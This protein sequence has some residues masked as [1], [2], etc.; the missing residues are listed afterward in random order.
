MM[1]NTDTNAAIEVHA[2]HEEELN[3]RIAKLNRKAERI[4][5]GTV[6]IVKT[7]FIK[8]EKTYNA[9]TDQ[10]HEIKYKM[11]SVDIVGEV[12]KI[13][14][15]DFIAK[16]DFE[17]GVP[18][19]SSAPDKEAPKWAR[20]TDTRCDHCTHNR[21]R[22]NVFILKN[23]EG[24]YIQVGRTCLKDFLGHDAK[25]IVALFTWLTC[26]SSDRDGNFGGWGENVADPVR[27]LAVTSLAIRNFGWNSRASVMN[28]DKIATADTVKTY[29]FPYSKSDRELVSEMGDVSEYDMDIAIKTMEFI[30]EMDKK[31]NK[32]DYEYNL[33]MLHNMGMIRARRIPLFAS[34]VGVYLRHTEKLAEIERQKNA[35][36]GSQHI[37]SV[38]ERL[39]FEATV[40][41]IHYFDGNFGTTAIVTFHDVDG[42]VLKWFTGGDFE[43]KRNTSVSVRGTVKSHGEYKGVKETVVTRCKVT[44]K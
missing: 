41:G 4:N 12:V 25:H 38:K 18:Y 40:Q 13:D 2:C 8:T 20:E 1:K 9:R 14:G 30:G 44:V 29:L 10:W 26:L 5:A 21:T 11:F 32:S 34:G 31:E 27:I 35:T 6:Q 3:K 17:D 7:P 24:E 43:M 42:N 15:Y 39:D 16:V 22:K 33:T 28:N 36:G 37:G 19:V 23:A